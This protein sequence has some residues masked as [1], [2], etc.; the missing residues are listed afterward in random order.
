MYRL[1]SDDAAKQKTA[2]DQ[3]PAEKFMDFFLFYLPYTT[4][5]ISLAVSLIVSTIEF[6]A[7]I[8]IPLFFF[9]AV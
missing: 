5:S 8:I 2:G 4:M 3:T 6:T 7:F 1:K 9:S